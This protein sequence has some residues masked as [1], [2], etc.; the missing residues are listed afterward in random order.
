MADP[1]LI[2]GIEID[3][4]KIHEQPINRIVRDYGIEFVDLPEEYQQ[5]EYIE[6]DGTSY[7]DTNY[8]PNASTCFTG[9]FQVSKND[10]ES[11]EYF[12]GSVDTYNSSRSWELKYK[13]STRTVIAEIGRITPNSIYVG[14]GENLYFEMSRAKSILNTSAVSV[15]DAVDDS[16]NYNAYIFALNHAGTAEY[17][18]S[19][20]LYSFKILEANDLVMNF[21]PCYRKSD[22]VTG[23]YDTVSGLFFSSASSTAFKKGENVNPS[24]YDKIT[25]GELYLNVFDENWDQ[26][27][28]IDEYE[29]LIWSDRFDEAGDFELVIPYDKTIFDLLKKD[30]FCTINLSEHGMVIE[31][32]EIEQ[33]YDDNPTLTVTGRSLE[34]LLERRV[35]PAKKEF[36]SDSTKVNLQDSVKTLLK[37]N[38]ISPDNENRKFPNFK[39]VASTD[40]EVTKLT[41]SETY[42]G[43]DLYSIITTLCQDKH[44]GFKIALDYWYHWNFSL[45]AGKDRSYEQD[46]NEYVIFS[47]YYDNLKNS[48]FFSSIEDYRNLMIVAKTE[49]TTVTVY[50]GT[51]PSGLDR[52]EIYINASEL[53]KNKNTELSTSKIRSKGKKKL[54]IDHKIKTAFEGD[55]IPDVLYYYRTDYFVGDKVQFEDNYGNSQALYIS[56]VVITKDAN[57]LSVIPT[58]KEIEEEWDA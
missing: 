2:Y 34:A 43:E 39:F 5:V 47:P 9:H 16:S 55:I 38:V 14:G 31:K 33:D 45:Y 54:E 1:S 23:L 7:I 13:P 42:N 41:M 52:R 29:S 51:E 32:V 22:S 24:G 18:G 21:I 49:T 28:V 10:I 48:R 15:H 57:G 58:F 19:G 20:K 26:V 12:F 17:Y 6:S 40:E 11:F 27:A 50:K 46:K 4:N 37:E 3:P 25:E 53:Q 36:G 35:V 8:K 56:E 44:I 30:Y